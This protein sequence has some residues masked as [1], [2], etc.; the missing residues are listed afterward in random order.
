MKARKDGCALCGSTWGNF[1]FEIEG[2]NRFFCCKVCAQSFKSLLRSIKEST[3]WPHITRLEISG[4]VYQR[5]VLAG[6]DEEEALFTVS[7]TSSGEISGFS[8]AKNL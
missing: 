1:W 2:I 8:K 6:F 7:F 3:G 5:A 4:D